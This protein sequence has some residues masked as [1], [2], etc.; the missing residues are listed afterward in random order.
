M[1]VTV[2]GQCS[3]LLSAELAG[4]IAA[5]CAGVPCAVNHVAMPPKEVVLALR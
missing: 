4:T 2:H 5:W 3:M 1:E